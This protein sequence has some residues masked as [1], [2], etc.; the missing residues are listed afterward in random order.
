MVPEFQQLL[1]LNAT[2][3]VLDNCSSPSLG[4][5]ASSFPTLATYPPGAS[6]SVHRRHLDNCAHPG[7]L[8][9][10]GVLILIGMTCVTDLSYLVKVALMMIYVGSAA[11]F[12]LLMIFPNFAQ[13]SR[14]EGAGNDENIEDGR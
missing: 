11:A 8:S 4:T 6:S 3:T 7:F 14:G 1:L 10:A 9:N 12:N 2:S 13:C 5:A